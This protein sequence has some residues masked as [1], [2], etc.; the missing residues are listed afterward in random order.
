MQ[1]E[2]AILETYKRAAKSKE[3]RLC[4]PVSYTRP[5]LLRVIPEEILERDYGCGDPTPYVREGEIVLDLGSGSG[6]HCYMIAQIVGPKG[7][8]IGIDFNDAM[9]ALARKYQREIADRLGY[10]NTEFRKAHIQN[11]RLDL[12]KVDNYLRD[13]PLKSS[14]DLIKFKEFAKALMEREP[15]IPDNSIDTVVSNCV[16]NLV[17]EDEKERLFNEIYRVLKPEG[18]AII[19]D[20]VSDEDVPEHLKKNP[21]LWSGCISGAL[22]E[23]KFLSAFLKAGF[24]SVRILKYEERPWQVVEGIEFRSITIEAVKG[25]KGACIDRGH[26]VIYLGPF[27]KVE[28]AE[29]HIYEV[30]KRVAVCEKT[31]ENLKKFAGDQFVFIAPAK[32]LTPRPFPCGEKIVYRSPKETKGGKWE[33][34]SLEASSCCAPVEFISFQEKLKNLGVNLKKGPIETIQINLGTKCNLQCRH[35]HLQAGPNGA[36]MDEKVLWACLELLKKNPGKILDLT[37]GAPELHPLIQDLISEAKPYVKDIYFRTN[38]LALFERENL[39]NFLAKEKVKI[40]GSFPDLVE[41]KADFFRGNGFYKGAFLALRKLNQLGFGRDL[42]LYLMVNPTELT[43]APEEETVKR[44]YQKFF[45]KEGLSFTDLFVLN[46]FPLGRFRKYLSKKGKLKAYYQLL[47]ANFNQETLDKLMCLSLLN[48]AADGTLYDC[49]FNQA[50]GLKIEAP[51]NIFELLE[52]GLK[53]LEGK[54][55]LIG[56]HC[57]GCTALFGTS[58]FGALT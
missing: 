54:A 4:C 16:L 57:Y 28:D 31:F 11:L 30:G 23:D 40:I 38:F 42:P 22:R 10:F 51:G 47:Y 26:A 25:K 45:E 7:K 50:L 53:A 49:D 17:R 27:L 37:G 24:G 52:T 58:C 39:V 41:K 56:D 35:C 12:E 29:G 44:E 18:R 19:S 3:T 34:N 14:E 13:N 15:L 2:S 5:E 55:I 32:K 6:K 20:I 46:N 43:L 33:S 48:I 9:L 36:L 8:V 1:V 21:E